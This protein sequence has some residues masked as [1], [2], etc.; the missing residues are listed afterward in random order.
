MKCR[1]LLHQRHPERRA[2]RPKPKDRLCEF[3]V[4]RREIIRTTYENAK[5]RG[6]RNVYFIDGEA[7]MAFCGNEGTVD[8]CHPTDLGFFSMAKALIELVEREGILG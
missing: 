5:A 1:P 6:D 8:N 4:G 3:E 7:L 2:A